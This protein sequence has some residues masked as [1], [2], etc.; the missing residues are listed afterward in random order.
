[1]GDLFPGESS[2]A[3]CL[4]LAA[5]AEERQVAESEK[6]CSWDSGEVLEDPRKERAAA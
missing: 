6:R 5:E 2:V 3:A 4:V 1:M